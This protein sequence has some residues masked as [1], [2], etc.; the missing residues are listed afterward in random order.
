[1]SHENDSICWRNSD[2]END[3]GFNNG[4]IYR[5][6]TVGVG[7]SKAKGQLCGSADLIAANPDFQPQPDVINGGYVS[8]GH[9]MDYNPPQGSQANRNT[10]YECNTGQ[11]IMTS[12]ASALNVSDPRYSA[13]Y[14]NP[15]LKQ[16]CLFIHLNYNPN[17]SN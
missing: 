12:P 5:S 16:V 13:T 3:G 11:N 4:T 17:L 6:S 15:Y 8:Y 14:G 9:V 1:M 2:M 7:G 10:I